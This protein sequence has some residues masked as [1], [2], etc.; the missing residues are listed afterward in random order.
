MLGTA[1]NR[2]PINYRQRRAKGDREVEGTA[3]GWHCSR[4]KF[5]NE[6]AVVAGNPCRR[7]SVLNIDVLLIWSLR[8]SRRTGRV[9]CR[10][11]DRGTKQSNLSQFFGNF[12]EEHLVQRFARNYIQG[13]RLQL[14]Q[15]CRAKVK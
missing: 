15:S 10:R 14:Y 11:A 5:G 8:G 3:L 6:L 2:V 13:A 4:A 12:V 1:R 7:L 9:F